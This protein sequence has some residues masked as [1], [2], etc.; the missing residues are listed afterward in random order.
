MRWYG[1]GHGLQTLRLGL[2]LVSCSIAALGGSTLSTLAATC[3]INDVGIST[4]P[5]TNTG[6]INCINI[7]SSTVSGDVT[8]AA[9]GTIS[10]FGV[11]S[12]D[13]ITI[14]NTSSI[15][16]SV[17]NGGTIT[18]SNS[19]INVNGVV[20]GGA[21]NSGTISAF[22]AIDIGASTFSGG[23][24]NSGTFLTG[25]DAI[26]AGVVSN[27][28]GGINNT[29]TITAGTT[30]AGS[31][32]ILLISDSTF[33][34]G[35]IN[36]GNLSANGDVIDVGNVSVYS[37]GIVNSGSITSTAGA[38]ISLDTGVSFSGG[39]SNT[40][41]I[42]TAGNGIVVSFLS[43]FSGGISNSGIITTVGDG[44][45]VSNVSTF[46]GNITNSGTITATT[47][48]FIGNSV[49]FAAG[50]AIVNSGTIVGT[51]G[52][53][54]DVSF[55]TSPVTIQQMGGA[56]N[57]AIKLSANADV[58]NIFGGTING[59]IVGAGASNAI[60]FA[61]GAGTFTYNSA[62]TNINQVSINSGTVVL[63]GT[64]S[65]T[66]FDV[67]GGALAG[68]GRINAP[69]VSIN[70]GA[71]F[72]PGAPRT[73]GTS[74][75]IGGNL[76][77]QSG[78]S[79]LV[80]LGSTASFANITGGAT[81]AGT[82]QTM[83][84]PAS[85]S[86]G[87]SY[88]ILH[89]TGGF[90]SSTFSGLD[91]SNLSGSL[92]YT[93]TDVFLTLT[94]ASLGAGAGLNQ[95]QHSVAGVINNFF[96]NGGTLPPGFGGLFGLTGGN[97]ANALTQISGETA[98]ATQQST[99]NAMTQFMGVMTDPFVNG[100]GYDAASTTGP[101]G[102]ADEGAMAY[103]GKRKP[104]DALAAI[105][106][107]ARPVAFV[108]SWSTWV[109]GYGGSQT[110]DGN[111]AIGSN[112]TTSSIYGTAVGADYRLSPNTVAGFA[113]AGGGTNFSVANSGSGR[114]DLFQAGAFVRHNEGPAYVLA[115][116]AYGWQ[117]ITTNRTVTVAGTDLLRAEF[118][119]NA[120]SGRLEGGYRFVA[121][122]SGG[123]G[124]TP[125]AAGQFTTFDLPAYMETALSGANAFALAYG[126]KDVTDPRSEL[127]LRTDKS[128][129]LPNGILTLRSRLAWAYDYDPNRSVGATFQSLPGA[130]FVVN[131]AAQAHDSALTTASIEMN[132]VNGWSA[133]A[134]F[135]GEF[136]PVTNSYAGKGV[137]R[138]TW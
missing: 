26:V 101:T 10:A 127:G 45:A 86:L 92:S 13:G 103:A 114:S 113:L 130:A 54:I 4:G 19:G 3:A 50:G 95:N 91:S 137:V 76:A 128:W 115:A 109:A 85:Y 132:W 72:L 11:P 129:A 37:G 21:V 116:L 108:P 35:I 117:D 123:I 53:A 33:S 105:Y 44:I 43:T 25:G 70:S 120:F 56:I 60:N 88:D 30:G 23:I 27:F 87:Q 20:S 32:A 40:G 73:P 90:A 5:V 104:N 57:G 63:N 15:A 67:N 69:V 2:A 100:R 82:V 66:R 42:S 64:N 14:T 62:F 18:A 68:T 119:A 98:A 48:I 124:I 138:Y 122:W 80:N 89:A 84:A 29:G 36:S 51:G 96:N 99:F 75:T 61:L 59:N 77:F 102:Y 7:Q 65:A 118:N 16:G 106:A 6:A 79:Y 133:A 39:I 126:A 52:T 71:T 24:R 121:P 74:M 110:T 22:N 38:G 112:S 41:V 12:Q 134:T 58:L 1:G 94:R 83:F 135:E 8:N 17:S 81:L 47:G 9:S 111:A 136:S 28:S 125:Y 49:S 97:L 34:G 46:G 31:N 131:G 107:K 55:A 93:A 78:A